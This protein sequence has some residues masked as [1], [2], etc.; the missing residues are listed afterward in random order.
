MAKRDL[1][2]RIND[3][4]IFLAFDIG[5][6][7]T[8]SASGSRFS[9]TATPAGTLVVNKGRHD[10]AGVDALINEWLPDAIVIGDPRSSEP[11]LNKAINRFKSHIHQHHK[12]PT[13]AI[14]E[15]LS[16]AAANESLAQRGLSQQRKTELRDQVA[17]ALI[18][19]SY[20]SSLN[21]G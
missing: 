11:H 7:R 21:E 2:A 12:L 10:W 9:K 14:D 13:I 6:K 20:F 4:E 8:G 16:S 1:K 3:A 17:A 19:E 15:R 18:P 5:L